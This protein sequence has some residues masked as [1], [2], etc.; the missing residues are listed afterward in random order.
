[1]RKIKIV[2]IGLMSM[3]VCVATTGCEGIDIRS[4]LLF[5]EDDN[6]D[7]V[8]ID[9]EKEFKQM[10]KFLEN[11]FCELNA[12]CRSIIDNIFRRIIDDT[13]MPEFWKESSVEFLYIIFIAIIHTDTQHR[14]FADVIKL[15]ST[16]TFDK[17]NCIDKDCDLAK[18]LINFRNSYSQSSKKYEQCETIL[19]IPKATFKPI[20]QIMIDNLSPYKDEVIE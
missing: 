10:V 12:N 11:P 7:S 13:L 1:M 4:S 19:N 15:L 9:I 6:E 5:L 18:L 2:F 14:T 3:L 20:K 16:A 17:N 8:Q